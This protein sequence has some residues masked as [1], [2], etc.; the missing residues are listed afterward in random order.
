M[1]TRRDIASDSAREN[2]ASQHKVR[3]LATCTISLLLLSACTESDHNS[4]ADSNSSTEQP[5]TSAAPS[6]TRAAGFQPASV[7]LSW[8][9]PTQRV[10]GSAL[11]VAEISGYEVALFEESS[12]RVSTYSIEHPLQ[13]QIRFEDLEP[14][15]YE[16]AV[17]AYDTENNIS[18][19]SSTM[20][21]GL[22]DFPSD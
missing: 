14:G 9:I 16:L 11:P 8:S 22:S 6:S 12:N 20:Q 7:S 19:P 5:T 2:T 17:F 10:D 13:N 18:S 3:A 21:I 15:S 1:P 4:Q